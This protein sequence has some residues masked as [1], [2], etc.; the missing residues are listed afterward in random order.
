MK[1]ISRRIFENQSGV[2]FVTAAFVVVVLIL[3]VGGLYTVGRKGYYNNKLCSVLQDTKERMKS[4]AVNLSALDLMITDAEG[5]AENLMQE[6]G[7]LNALEMTPVLNGSAVRYVSVITPGA[8]RRVLQKV[9]NDYS[10]GETTYN[11][12]SGGT[13]IAHPSDV[14]VGTPVNLYTVSIYWDP[15]PAA[16]YTQMFAE[17]FRNN[18]TIISAAGEFSAFGYKIPVRCSIN[19]SIELIVADPF[20]PGLKPVPSVTPAS[21]DT[22]DDDAGVYSDGDVAGSRTIFARSFNPVDHDCSN[23][24]SAT[25]SALG[26]MCE[27]GRGTEYDE[28]GS[29]PCAIPCCKCGGWE[30]ENR[31]GMARVAT[32]SVTANPGGGGSYVTRIRRPPEMCPFCVAYKR[33]GWD[34]TPPPPPPPPPPTPWPACEGCGPTD[35]GNGMTQEP[36]GDPPP[37]LCEPKW[38]CCSQQWVEASAVYQSCPFQSCPNA[39]MQIWNQ[40]PASSGGAACSCT[41]CG[42]GGGGDPLDNCRNNPPGCL[43]ESTVVC[44]ACPPGLGVGSFYNPAQNYGCD[45]SGMGYFAAVCENL[46]TGL[47]VPIGMLPSAFLNQISSGDLMYNQGTG[48]ATCTNPGQILRHTGCGDSS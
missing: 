1:H 6:R 19:T 3:L 11:D 48:M 39:A 12:F 18:P 46:S 5:Y 40:G 43:N 23:P 41:P 27:Q 15:S 13:F 8:T 42:G 33:E 44:G 35:A 10:G 30:Y 9:A 25:N 38:I 21:V 24:I 16:D 20:P 28:T 32:G 34:P 45:S 31:Y 22:D 36:V 29:S 4:A 26:S 14:E 17:V 2:T 47:P 7:V 37:E